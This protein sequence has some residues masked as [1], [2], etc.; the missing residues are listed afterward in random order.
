MEYNQND[1]IEFLNTGVALEAFAKCNDETQAIIH[2]CASRSM[3]TLQ[4]R[5]A[6]GYEA[7]TYLLS[8]AGL[9][10]IQGLVMKIVPLT[11]KVLTEVTT[12]ELTLLSQ[13]SS[14]ADSYTVPRVLGAFELKGQKVLVIEMLSGKMATE[15]VLGE[16]EIISVARAIGHLQHSLAV[17]E[18]GRAK[19]ARMSSSSEEPYYVL[20]AM[21][22]V[23]T[24]LGLSVSREEVS[25]LEVLEPLRMASP[26]IVSDR[27]PANMFINKE[28]VCMFDFGLILVGLPFEDWSWFIDDPRMVSELTREDIVS[29]FWKSLERPTKS[30]ADTIKIFHVSAIF[31]CIKQYCLMKSIGRYDMAAHYMQR[32]LMSAE[33]INSNVALELIKKLRSAS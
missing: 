14:K 26:T 17:T 11:N 19:I 18:F 1:L 25:F 13:L 24:Y 27:S 16:R 21:K 22:F 5:R 15:R 20:K 6:S 32:A 31:V 3:M 7:S 4:T 28:T 10:H 23:E 12:Q 33:S 8:F 9:T 30:F 29:I 2:L